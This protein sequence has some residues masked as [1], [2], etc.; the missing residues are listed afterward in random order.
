MTFYDRYACTAEKRGM[1]PCS[2]KTADTL[3]LTRAAI[4]T[5]KT[6]GSTP[7][8]EAVARIADM[9]TVST[10]YLLG[11][12]DDPTDYTQRDRDPAKVQ[13]IE[14]RPELQKTVPIRKPVKTQNKDSI[15]MTLFSRLD[16]ADKNKAQGV[17]QGLLLQ[18]K[19]VGSSLNAAHIRTDVSV[20]PDMITHDEE[21]MDDENF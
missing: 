19:Y 8:G 21:I 4:S 12:T 5:W 13:P 16:D 15:L 9:L 2:Q 14:P 1:D 10:D 7:K 20:T 3:G 18:D 6:K 17:I 11:R